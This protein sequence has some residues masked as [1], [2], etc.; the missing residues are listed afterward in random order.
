[1]KINLLYNSND[2]LNDY[3]NIDHVEDGPDKIHGLV[4]DL[5]EF[6]EPAQCKSLIAMDVIDKFPA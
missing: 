4:D 6:C 2:I 1:M 3:L 5:D